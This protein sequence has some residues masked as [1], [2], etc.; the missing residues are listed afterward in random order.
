MHV[1]CC[2]HYEVILFDSF[3]FN[4][5]FFLLVSLF[6]LKTNK[7]FIFVMETKIYIVHSLLLHMSKDSTPISN[8]TLLV[9][10][11]MYVTVRRWMKDQTQKVNID[12]R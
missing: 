1:Y 11:Y 4:M 8:F 12:M 6:L 3:N 7:G 5:W 10:I 2:Q 9:G